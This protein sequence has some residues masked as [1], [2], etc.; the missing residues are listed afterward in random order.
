MS[1]VEFWLH[2]SIEMNTYYGTLTLIFY[3]QVFN[4]LMEYKNTRSSPIPKSRF[5]DLIAF[6]SLSTCIIIFYMI[7][8]IV[9]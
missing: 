5:V 8:Y 6:M 7:R 9:W 4:V 1:C 3:N 2:V